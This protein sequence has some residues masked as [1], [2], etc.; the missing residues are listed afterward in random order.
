MAVR[1]TILGSGSGGNAAILATSRTTLL[2]DAG[3]SLREL[4]RRMALAGQGP[5]QLDGI[6]ITHEHTD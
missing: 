3:F 5:E 1:L 6:L 4:T 2:L